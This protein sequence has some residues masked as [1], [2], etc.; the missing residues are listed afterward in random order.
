MLK[1]GNSKHD[2][3][4][5]A[6][7]QFPVGKFMVVAAEEIVERDASD[8]MADGSL[9]AAQEAM[10]F[11]EVGKLAAADDLEESISHKA[12]LELAMGKLLGAAATWSAP[13]TEEQWESFQHV[14][15]AI[16]NSVANPV[17]LVATKVASDLSPALEKADITASSYMKR[18][19]VWPGNFLVNLGERAA[20]LKPILENVKRAVE[21][22]VTSIV[23][24]LENLHRVLKLPKVAVTSYFTKV[25]SECQK[26]LGFG[27]GFSSFVDGVIACEAVL[28]SKA[29]GP[30]ILIE[31][32]MSW[33]SASAK[34]K[35][36]SEDTEEAFE[37]SVPWL[38]CGLSIYQ[39]KNVAA[40]MI[41][42]D[43]LF[44]AVCAG[45]PSERQLYGLSGWLSSSQTI[46]F[47]DATLW[48]PTL[49]KCI[50]SLQAVIS[51]KTINTID[52]AT[53]SREV[54]GD[55]LSLLIGQNLASLALVAKEHMDFAE[56]EVKIMPHTRQALALKSLLVESTMGDMGVD[57]GLGF[58]FE[59][60]QHTPA[61][62]SPLT[63]TA[64]GEALLIYSQMYTCMVIA[65]LLNSALWSDNVQLFNLPNVKNV[66]K[67]HPGNAQETGASSSVGIM[68]AP[69]AMVKSLA[70][71][72][73]DLEARLSGN[74]HGLDGTGLNLHK[75]IA[76]C[77]LWAANMYTFL[78]GARKRI[79]ALA[80]AE[81]KTQS[82]I[83]EGS[84]P[85]WDAI[86]K[87]GTYDM[88]IAKQKVLEHPK[89]P[90]IKPL[91]SFEKV[92]LGEVVALSQEWGIASQIKPGTRSLIEATIDAG[93]QY[94]TIAAAV[95]TIA[96]FGHSLKAPAMAEGVLKVVAK[97]E[98]AGFAMPECLRTELE[99]M[100]V[101][102]PQKDPPPPESRDSCSDKETADAQGVASSGSNTGAQEKLKKDEDSDDDPAMDTSSQV[103]SVHVK[104]E[105]SELGKRG[106]FAAGS[107]AAK[108]ARVSSV[109]KASRRERE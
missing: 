63:G 85:R 14:I 98:A 26:I 20:V 95:N 30:Q 18:G 81:L 45:F 69:L 104:Q 40:S 77:K 19:T 60:L 84:L 75:S 87:S 107:P 92:V 97:Q 74:Q 99:A 82:D 27:Q 28:A 38:A 51:I 43:G 35:P 47:I 76:N 93:C 22:N 10:S 24:F 103:T 65:A 16:V 96:N 73:G 108:K 46:S 52:E 7:F 54:T 102:M 72:I 70:V 79:L 25:K 37:G 39:S 1:A 86:F 4:C 6:F 78:V 55:F 67:K 31:Q 33:R 12:G 41:A 109:R 15:T 8:I 56:G 100:K 23:A 36:D 62:A 89:R 9:K 68:A 71:A 66:M 44:R 17:A 80:A 13:R 90:M 53:A 101:G 64:C 88:A 83:L 5:Q 57:F 105:F 61:S 91:V 50:G 34:T 21:A 48:R 58:V 59:P 32:F 29:A 106:S 11:A 3:F 94:L 49:Q 2:I 42:D